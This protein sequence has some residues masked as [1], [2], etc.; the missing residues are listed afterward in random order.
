MNYIFLSIYYLKIIYNILL[1][2]ISELILC[3][4]TFSFICFFFSWLYYIRK[5]L[6]HVAVY[7]CISLA[8]HDQP[9]DGKV[10]R[11]MNGK[12]AVLKFSS[13]R[14]LGR[15]EAISWLVKIKLT[16]GKEYRFKSKRLRLKNINSLDSITWG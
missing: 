7:F 6:L 5:T 9:E 8:Q 3:E 11:K 13:V 2:L 4:D 12:R 14:T 10:E 16:L 15:E 1:S